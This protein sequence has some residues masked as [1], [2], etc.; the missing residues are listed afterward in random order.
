MILTIIITPFFF[1]IQGHTALKVESLSCLIWPKAWWG[2]VK[3]CCGFEKKI[4]CF[5]TWHRVGGSMKFS[6]VQ[7]ILFWLFV[8]L[9]WSLKTRVR[10]CLKKLE[11]GQS[12]W[13][14]AE[15]LASIK[16]L[17][18]LSL[19]LICGPPKGQGNMDFFL[20]RETCWK[21]LGLIHFSLYCWKSFQHVSVHYLAIGERVQQR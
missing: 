20:P 9:R 11:R 3:V 5:E 8:K 17:N 7:A 18:T 4:N 19:P 10:L 21:V 6:M 16:L 1:F 12:C 14:K 13:H 2:L 15:P